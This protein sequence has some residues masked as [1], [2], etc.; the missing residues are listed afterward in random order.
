MLKIDEN[1]CQMM[2]Y[3]YFSLMT[4]VFAI[5]ETRDGQNWVMG[6]NSTD[7]AS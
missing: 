2:D 7:N 3:S 5:Y 1:V 6:N 4:A